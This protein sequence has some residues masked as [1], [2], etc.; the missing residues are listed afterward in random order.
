MTSDTTVDLMTKNTGNVLETRTVSASSGIQNLRLQ[1]QP[2]MGELTFQVDYDKGLGAGPKV[3]Q[4]HHLFKMVM[5]L[6]R[7]SQT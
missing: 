5:Q 2:L 3:K 1:K 6:E 4:I 7:V